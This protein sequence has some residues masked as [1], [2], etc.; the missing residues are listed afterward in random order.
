MWP[1]LGLGVAA[2]Q[3]PPLPSDL[4]DQ[5]PRP[6]RVVFQVAAPFEPVIAA[7]QLRFVRGGESRVLDLVDDGGSPVDAAW[8]GVWAGLDEG[9]WA[10]ALNVEMTVI[11]GDGQPLTAW[12]GLVGTEERFTT[13]VAWQ[14]RRDPEGM[15]ALRVAAAWPEDTVVVPDGLG[16]WVGLG[17]ACLLLGWVAAMV[18]SR[19]APGPGAGA[20]S[21]SAPATGEPAGGGAAGGGPA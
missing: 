14:L 5:D 17:W 21:S 2:A 8:D 6:Q 19:R 11:A 16:V 20:G 18:P 1:L 13:V 9:P 15:R 3:S 10:R 4:F 7:V 12:T